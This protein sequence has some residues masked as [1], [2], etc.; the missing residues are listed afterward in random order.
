MLIGDDTEGSYSL[1]LE[2]TKGTLYN[3]QYTIFGVH[4]PGQAMD[5]I[6]TRCSTEGKEV[7]NF[8]FNIITGRFRSKRPPSVWCNSQRAVI[9]AITSAR[10]I[11]TWS[12]VWLANLASV[13]A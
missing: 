12:A 3:P 5:T 2:G 7:A 8:R 10:P 4:E 9:A 6:T 11:H 1:P 13:H